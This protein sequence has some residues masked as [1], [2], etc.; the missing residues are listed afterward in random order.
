MIP[1]LDK[2]FVRVVEKMGGDF[3]IVQAARVCTATES[4]DEQ[5]D[6]KLIRY[7]WANGHTSPFEMAEIKL[8]IKAPIF[9]ARQWVRHRTANW[10]EVSGRYTEMEPEFYIP[11]LDAISAQSSSN[12]QGRGALLPRVKRKMARTAI[13]LASEAAFRVYRKLLRLGVSR[14]LARIILPLNLYTEWYWKIDVRNLLHFL[15]LRTDEHAQYEIR[16]YAEAI[17][18]IL[19]EWMPWTHDEA[20]RRSD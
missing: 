1:V 17:A 12:R 7:L 15:K 20:F 3:S 16:V 6:R 4:V 18:A 2:G 13:E 19:A 5:R 11:E 9:V 10:N 14:E 8:H